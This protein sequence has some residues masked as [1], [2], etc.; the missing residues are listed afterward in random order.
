[1]GQI[2]EIMNT[3]YGPIIISSLLG[4]GLAA[5]FRKVCDGKSCIVIKS[6]NAEEI[7]K[8][9]YKIQDDCYQY[10]AEKVQCNK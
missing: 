5:L 3:M 7:E 6:P 8:Y 1:M 2:T 4:L 9:Y 10:T